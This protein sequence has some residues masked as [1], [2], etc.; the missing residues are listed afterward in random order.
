MKAAVAA[1]VV[2]AGLPEL[3]VPAPAESP[4]MAPVRRYI[5][6]FNHGDLHAAAAAFA[7][8]A[9]IIDEVPPYLWRGR[10]A[11]SQWATDVGR[12]AVANNIADAR[13]TLGAPQRA[14][15]R[16]ER[17][18]LVVSEDFEYRQDGRMMRIAGLHVF[19]L[20]RTPGGWKIT[21]SAWTSGEPRPIAEGIADRPGPIAQSPFPSVHS[22]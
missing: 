5:D 20:R 11:V 16:G 12:D 14:D 17:G 9:I 19:S 8:D 6:G 1:L 21:A 13:A 7:P 2:A 3:T 15:I 10:Q 22:Q 4:L 18:Y